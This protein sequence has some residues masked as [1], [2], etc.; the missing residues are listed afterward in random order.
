MED[1]EDVSKIHKIANQ[2]LNRA[3]RLKKEDSIHESDFEVDESESEPE[4][5]ED[6]PERKILKKLFRKVVF[7]CHP[8]RIPN[9]TSDSK[10]E[11]LVSLYE[12]A[13]KAHDT[14][15][16]GKMIVV[17]IKL[18]IDLPDEAE[19]MLSKIEEDTNR[20]KTE[21]EQLTNSFAWNWYHAEE[22]IRAKM[23]ENY[24]NVLKT[25]KEKNTVKQREEDKQSKILVVGHPRTGTGYTAK[26]LKSWGLDIGHEKMGENGISA[27]QLAVQHE[28][29][30]VYL[31]V[32]YEQFDWSSVIYCVRDPKFSIPSI[33]YTENN[34][35]ESLEYR[36]K[37]GSF[38]IHT[39]PIINAIRSI[40]AWDKL[41]KK[42]K[43]DCTY[44]IEDQD[45]LLFK[46]IS[47]KENL[48]YSDVFVNKKQNQRKHPDWDQM[49]NEYGTV[50]DRHIKMLDDFCKQY[51]YKNPFR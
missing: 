8:D 24:L 43:V 30:P 15:D 49:I 13:V 1:I 9:E 20:L 7:K 16:W 22:G 48:K 32:N 35:K 39:N 51:G 10:V 45:Q 26:L 17:A 21:I 37:Y 4:I 28:K 14:N 47:S 44:R 33:V 23:I 12:K 3:I 5:F 42:I 25:I 36:Q 18:E 40:V 6:T 29:N 50:A 31:N 19:T 2:E 34:K 38:P 11:Y 46:F 41:I 27:W